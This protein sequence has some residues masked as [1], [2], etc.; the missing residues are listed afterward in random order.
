MPSAAGP[1]K[2]T[3]LTRLFRD[4]GARMVDFA[5]WELPVQFSS[6]LEEHQAV[7]TAAGLF[8]VSHMG[9]VEVRGRAA[10]EVVQ[11]L[12][13]NDVSRLGPGQAQYTALTT[14]KGTFVDDIIVYRRDEDDF[15]LVVNASNTDKDFAW[16]ASQARGQ[17]EVI[18]ASARYAQLALQGPRA[19]AILQTLVQVPLA[20]IRSFHFIETAV[21][22]TKC[23]VARTGYTGEDGFEIYAP[24]GD[25]PDLFSALVREG[26]PHGLLPCGLGARDTLRLEARLL[27]YGNDL[28]ETTTVLEAGLDSIV[29]LGKGPFIG[30]EA[31]TREKERGPLR[32]LMGFEMIDA[33]IP[34]HGYPIRVEGAETGAVTSGTF[35]PTVKKSIG[36]AYFPSRAAGV[37]TR[38]S[39]GIR[40]RDAQ[41]VIVPTPF[42]R[43]AH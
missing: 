22:G 36:L 28:D 31:L 29:K 11:K 1:L 37:G 34:R 7:R 30:S 43:R 15:L 6:V 5:G 8:D 17:V 16:I 21:G 38:F 20:P 25:A 33:G 12:T 40:G 3:A 35:G 19:R 14:D 13:S 27:L 32:R 39:V 10:L 2:T 41:A 9:E 24:P 26:S 23:I 18:N 42:Y 4:M